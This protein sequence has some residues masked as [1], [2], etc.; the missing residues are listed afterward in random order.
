[1]GIVLGV[2]GWFA[3]GK[4]VACKYFDDKGFFEIDVDLVGKKALHY[5][6]SEIVEEFGES[7]LDDNDKISP[8]K[9]GN[10]VF[11]GRENIARLNRIVHPWIRERVGALI[12][13]HR[14]E[15]I[16]VNAAI[17]PQL[18]LKPYCDRVLMIDAP[19]ELIIERG[20]K[21]NGFPSEKVKSILEI[22]K[23]N[24]A[25]FETADDVIRN[26]GTLKEFYEKLDVYYE[27]IKEGNHD[28]GRG[29]T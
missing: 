14:N 4:S 28:T 8:Q 2:M 3:S 27:K 15:D 24:N 1:M 29:T 26:D 25:Y 20:K 17:L 10:L 22:Q 12:R 19:K 21:R 6:K 16:L 9:L 13:Q 7:I 18:K 5:K 23:K 11:T